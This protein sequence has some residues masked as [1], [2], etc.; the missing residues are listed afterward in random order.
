M[1]P[2]TRIRNLL[3]NPAL[4]PETRSEL[5]A[6]LNHLLSV[7][8]QADAAAEQARAQALQPGDRAIQQGFTELRSSMTTEIQSLNN[9]WSAK[10]AAAEAARKKEMLDAYRV[11]ALRAAGDELILEMVASGP[12]IADIDASIAASK[13]KYKEIQARVAPPPPPAPPTPANPPPAVVVQQ[14][15]GPTG[16]PINPQAAAGFPQATNPAPVYNDPNNGTGFQA[17]EVFQQMTTEEAVRSGAYGKVR[18]DTINRLRGVTTMGGAPLGTAPR[19]I[20]HPSQHVQLPGGVSHPATQPMNPNNPQPT[21]QQQVS[22]VPQNVQ[23]ATPPAAPPPQPQNPPP[24]GANG[25]PAAPDAAAAMAA[26]ARTHANANP[27]AGQNPGGAAAAADA[28][29]LAAAGVNPQ[30]AYNQ[31][32]THTPPVS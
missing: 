15:F 16:Q 5:E 18:Q 4:T 30:A 23:V 13:A 32:F 19:Y 27:V 11:S 12:E 17:P 29:R 31:R 22:Q 9:A 14:Q 7:K 25:Y 3:Q 2:I 10:F 1:D 8:A 21:V 6:T 20:T 26:V 28:A 24:A